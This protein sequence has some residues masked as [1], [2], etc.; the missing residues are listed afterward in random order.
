MPKKRPFARD[1]AYKKLLDLII[2]DELSPDEPLSERSLSES[3]G[4]GRMPVRE[5]IRKLVHDGALEVLPAR[6]TFV[7]RIDLEQLHELYEVRQSIEGLAVFLAA[8]R[9]PTPE[10]SEYGRRFLA[11]KEMKEPADFSEIYYEGADFHVEVFRA[12]RNQILMDIYHPIRMRFRV[13]FGLAQ[14]Y[15]H[16][17]V[18]GSIDQHLAILRAIELG[19]GL[20]AQRMMGDHLARGYESKIKIMSRHLDKKTVV[21]PLP[22]AGAVSREKA[23]RKTARKP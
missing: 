13:A 5:A 22:V 23:R 7:R 6:G 16:D 1:E 11:A 2:S 14:Y 20:G 4:I 17:W 10:L 3:L 19:D 15:D 21:Y 18:I 9:G 8:Q 12:A